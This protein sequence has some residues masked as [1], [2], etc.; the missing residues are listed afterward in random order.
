MIH[1]Y[2]ELPDGQPWPDPSDPLGIEAKLRS[3]AEMTE[4]ERR[5]AASFIAAFRLLILLPDEERDWTAKQLDPL[6]LKR[7]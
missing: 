4:D 1:P 2:F 6:A 5:T 3:G 7:R